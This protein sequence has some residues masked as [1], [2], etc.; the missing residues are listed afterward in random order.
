MLELKIENNTTALIMGWMATSIIIV[1]RKLHSQMH[2]RVV[3]E[4]FT[5]TADRAAISFCIL[6]SYSLC[7][8]LSS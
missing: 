8:R 5:I 3:I 6:Y 1:S 4:T 7:T 2:W